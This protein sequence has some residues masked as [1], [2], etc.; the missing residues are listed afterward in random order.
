MAELSRYKLGRI[1]ATDADGYHRVACPAVLGKLRCPLRADSIALTLDH[2]EVL[3]P[4]E[5]PPACCTQSTITVPP[6]VNAKTAQRQDYLSKAW[7]RSCA[8]RSAA[9]RANARIKDPAT[10]DIGRGWCRVM[11]LAPMSLFLACALVVRNLA[12]A[13]AFD[14]RQAQDMRRVK[15]GLPRRTRRR[16]RTPISDLV[17]A[18]ANA[19]P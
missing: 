11:G 16:R 10:I 17:R 12:V 5:H 13:D 3:A 14:R 9:E 8:R 15:A 1:S 19:S 18:T 4:P 2:P 7:R 6:Q